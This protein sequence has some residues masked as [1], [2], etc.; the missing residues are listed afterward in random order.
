MRR[1]ICLLLVAGAAQA[2]GR[3]PDL[4]EAVEF[5]YSSVPRQLWERELV[6]LKNIGIRTV[7]CSIVTREPYG[8]GNP[9]LDFPGFLRILRR[10]DMKLWIRSG[11]VGRELATQFDTHG[12]PLAWIENPSAQAGLPQPPAPVTVVSLTD[13]AALVKSRLALAAGHGTVLWRDVEDAVTPGSGPRLHK[14][15]VSLSGEER[16]STEALRRDALLLRYWG[17]ALESV[18]TRS[19]RA[20]GVKARQL[21]I[22]G[23]S[24][25]SLTNEGQSS[26]RGALRVFYPPSNR[27]IALAPIELPRGQSLWLPVGVPLG[28][29]PLCRDCAVFG[30][31]DRIVYATAELNMLEFENGILAMEFAAPA[32]GEVV[33][34]L[35]RKPSGP[36]LAAGHPASFDWDERNLRA[37]LHIPAG[38]GQGHRVRVGLA[39]EAPEQSAFFADASRLIVGHVNEVRTSYSSEAIAKRSR[40]RLPPKFQAAAVTRSPA[41]IVYRVETPPDALHGE[42]ADFALEADGVL[43][44]HARLQLLRPA[45]MRIREAV[46][47]HFGP[48]T[49]LPIEPPLVTIDPRAGREITVTIR[50]NFPEI[51]NYTLEAEGADF[52][53]SPKRAAISIG[54]A[55]ERDVSIR[56]FAE[57]APSG[58]QPWRLRLTGG[59]SVE[60]QA[61]FVV[62]PRART[63]SWTADLY[64][65]GNTEWVLENQKVRAVFAPREAGRWLE[66]VWKESGVNLLPAAGA[67][68]GNGAAEAKAVENGIEFTGQGWTRT[69]RL[70]G[71]DSRVVIEQSPGAPSD[72]PG[73]ERRAGVQLK[74]DWRSGGRAVYELAR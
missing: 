15:A 44:S 70:A 29:G 23:A 32:A 28:S 65:D 25:V 38:T 21:S 7:A 55:L 53:F 6:W 26:W 45:S 41:E 67:L 52:D 68:A 46:S 37:R 31:N 12:G 14:G 56:V 39:I 36:L 10:L 57:N 8:G 2:A 63:V 72:S 74:I 13:P 61:R 58:I 66:F 17:P 22:P 60:M 33:L 59:A 20:V 3:N 4:L 30:G 49:E 40:L 51:R 1:W 62:I 24:M 27:F 71:D 48:D 54:P 47:S 50:N 16:S 69:V 35:S 42:F 19:I 11:L 73:A 34:Q 5:P 64:G 18:R 43:M 9:R